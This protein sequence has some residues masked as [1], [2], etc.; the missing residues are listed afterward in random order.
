[1]SQYSAA[2]LQSSTRSFATKT[3]YCRK[4]SYVFIIKSNVW[5][6]SLIAKML[7]KRLKPTNKK[8][9]WMLHVYILAFLLVLLTGS[10]WVWQGHS[11]C[12]SVCM[13][14]RMKGEEG[15]EDCVLLSSGTMLWQGTHLSCFYV[16]WGAGAGSGR[17]L[18]TGE[19]SAVSVNGGIHPIK[20]L[21]FLT[22]CI[23]WEEKIIFC[24]LI[25]EH[26]LKVK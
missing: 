9:P 26:F 7:V 19:L 25:E 16:S 18:G 22:C 12:C 24:L 1:M 13:E 2:A 17:G 14:L 11:C 10:F 5:A 6:K 8:K 20:R 4:Q 3:Y 23:A 15:V 21:Y